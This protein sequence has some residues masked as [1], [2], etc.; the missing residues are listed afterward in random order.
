MTFEEQYPSLYNQGWQTLGEVIPFTRWMD[1]DCKLMV[2]KHCLDKQKVKE[3]IERGKVC[4]PFVGSDDAKKG[5]VLWLD[6]L[7]EELGLEV[8]DNGRKT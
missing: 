4:N 5:F 1:K 8:V 3:A 6:N 7:L 2:Q